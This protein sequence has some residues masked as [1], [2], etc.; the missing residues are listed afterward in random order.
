M[1]YLKGVKE[2]NSRA[3]CGNLVS[4]LPL[5]IP[6]CMVSKLSQLMKRIK[7][8]APDQLVICNTFSAS[9]SGILY[10]STVLDK[11]IWTRGA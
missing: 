5:F 2:A 8:L 11:R 7:R 1:L 4:S 9:T 10:K 6:S 3:A